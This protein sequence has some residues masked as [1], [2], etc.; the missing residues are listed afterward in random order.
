MTNTGRF[1]EVPRGVTEVTETEQNG[2]SQGLG[3]GEGGGFHGDGASV[4]ENEKF[5]GW[6]RG[7][8]HNNMDVLNATELHT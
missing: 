6:W 4:W 2:G 8:L 7:S 3:E 5:W 1:H